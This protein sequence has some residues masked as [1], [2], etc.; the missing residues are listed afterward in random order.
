MSVTSTVKLNNLSEKI[1]YIRFS[2]SLSASALT[3]MTQLFG[4]LIQ[5]LTSKDE[6]GNETAL[7]GTYEEIK[8]LTGIPVAS[9]CRASRA[10]KEQKYMR[11]NGASAY[12]FEHDKVQGRKWNC[13]IEVICREFDM[14]DDDGNQ[15]K[16]KLTPDWVHVYA[17][18][19]TKRKCGVYAANKEI[20]DE[21]GIDPDTVATALTYLRWAKLIYFPKANVG[22]N[23]YKKNRIKLTTRWKWFKQEKEYRKRLE[24][25]ET[26]EEA[27]ESTREIYYSRL[28]NKAR[29]KA[30]TAKNKALKNVDYNAVMTEISSVRALA[31][32]A[33]TPQQE[34]AFEA[35]I[36]A[37]YVKRD[38]TLKNIGLTDEQLFP[39]FYVKCKCC[40]DTGFTPD[41]TACD[42]YERRRSRGSPPKGKRTT[43]GNE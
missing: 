27:E 24:P 29:K 1:Y 9:I 30:E 43:K 16:R 41:G 38:G 42:C 28:Q 25:Q 21:L 31:F 18:V 13:P 36:N 15:F 32:R 34:Q 12:V 11:K 37:L 20:A 35:Q 8:K 3:P 2:R 19:Y 5:S 26:D 14:T 6:Q 7:E 40:K 17:Y 4:G 39:D 33:C 23:G 10:L 22:V